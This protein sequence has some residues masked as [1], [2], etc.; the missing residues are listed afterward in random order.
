MRFGERAAPDLVTAVMFNK[1]FNIADRPS[2]P[3][4]EQVQAVTLCGSVAFF[5]KQK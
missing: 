4:K 2:A 1:G 5:A 3:A